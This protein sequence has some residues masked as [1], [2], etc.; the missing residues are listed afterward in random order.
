MTVGELIDKLSELPENYDVLV[1]CYM[2]GEVYACDPEIECQDYNKRVWI[3][4]GECVEN[5]EN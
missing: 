4:P 5:E 1:H 3:I 2:D